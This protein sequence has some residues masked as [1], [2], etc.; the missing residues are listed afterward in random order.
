[1]PK[2]E[3]TT[4][5]RVVMLEISGLTKDEYTRWRELMD[6]CRGI[7]NCTWQSWLVWHIQNGTRALIQ[8]YLADAKSW[9]DG[10]E[11]GKKPEWPVKAVP[12]ECAKLTYDEC[13][14]TFPHIETTARELCRNTVIQKINHTKAAHGSL[15][16][17]AAILLHHQS[18]P[19]TVRGVPIPFSK[20][21]ARIEP[22][23]PK[24][25]NACWKLHVKV[26]RRPQPGKKVGAAVTDTVKLWS[27]GRK[28]ASAVATLKKIAAGEYAF[29][30]SNLIYKESKK[31]WFAAICYRAPIEPAKKLDK[32]VQA[33]L[34]PAPIS[35]VWQHPWRLR[36]PGTNRAPGGRG[37]YI[38]AVR[39]KIFA[40]RRSRQNG[41]RHAG[42]ANK[43]HGRDRA[44]QPTWQLE[45]RWKDFVKTCNYMVARD[46]VNQ[47]VACGVG[48][49]VYFQ[50]GDRVRDSRFLTVI[51]KRDDVP[52][53]SGWDYYQIGKRLSDLCQEFGVEF[54]WRK[55]SDRAREVGNKMAKTISQKG[56]ARNTNSKASNSAALRGKR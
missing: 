39:R 34:R 36:F 13:A 41:Y 5:V 48:T 2:K 4:R 35:A 15:S 16:G 33:F 17:W 32:E 18:L 53:S 22:P 9:R 42:S 43:G 45:Q 11:K 55:P 31:K 56:T 7:V 44:L 50:P 12:K 52:E 51:G 40:E 37:E 21:N 6:D 8:K 49:L 30:G 19:S 23:D 20:R 38:A 27:K 46:V 14:A 47:C 1:M 28:A 54:V 26:T 25:E 24:G 29:C 3:K 10:G